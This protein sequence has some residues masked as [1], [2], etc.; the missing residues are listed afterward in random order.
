MFLCLPGEE[1]EE[2]ALQTVWTEAVPAEGLM[3]PERL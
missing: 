1:G 3:L 2:V